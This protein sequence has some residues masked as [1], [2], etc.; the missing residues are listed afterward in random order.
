MQCECVFMSWSIFVCVCV[1]VDGWVWAYNYHYVCQ[2]V[3]NVILHVY[4]P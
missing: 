4:H 3:N 1:W 2:H